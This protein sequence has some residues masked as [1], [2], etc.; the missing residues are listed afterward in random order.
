MEVFWTIG[1]IA[2]ILAFGLGIYNYMKG[3]DDANIK[4][5]KIVDRKD[6]EYYETF[7]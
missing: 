7:K 1:A 6:K 3:R 4:G 5:N 2:G